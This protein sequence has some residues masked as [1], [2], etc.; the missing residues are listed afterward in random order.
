MMRTRGF[1]EATLVVSG[2]LY[3]TSNTYFNALWKVKWMLAKEASNENATIRSMVV[4][5]KEFLK[6]WK[7]SYLTM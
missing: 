5:M 3:P 7:L 1:Y 4:E 2:S 6:Y